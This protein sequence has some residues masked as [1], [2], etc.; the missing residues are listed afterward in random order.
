VV[1]VADSVIRYEVASDV[2]WHCKGRD[3]D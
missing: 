1:A 3:R 2:V